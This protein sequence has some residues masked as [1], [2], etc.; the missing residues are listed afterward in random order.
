V[1]LECVDAGGEWTV[2]A[3]DAGGLVVGDT[4]GEWRALRTAIICPADTTRVRIDLRNPGSGEVAYRQVR[5]WMIA[6]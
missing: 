2:I 4:G 3:P 1:Y 5:M 6:P